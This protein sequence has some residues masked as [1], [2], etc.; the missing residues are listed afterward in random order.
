MI[1]STNTT[2]HLI[3]HRRR[4]ATSHA[5]LAPPSRND[6]PPPGIS[7]SIPLSSQARTT[8]VL[9][10]GINPPHAVEWH[11][12]RHLCSST[13]RRISFGEGSLTESAATFDAHSPTT[14]PK[15]TFSPTFIHIL[16]VVPH[17]NQTFSHHKAERS[18]SDF[19]PFN[20][21]NASDNRR[22]SKI[23]RAIIA[24][25]ELTPTYHWNTESIPFTAQKRIAP[26]LCADQRPGHGICALN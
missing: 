6:L 26:H 14:K 1:P 19:L 10:R 17:L 23:F 7:A 4:E 20:P 3:H 22:S 9:G 12:V 8:Q 11:E 25:G 5:T 15:S 24:R 13:V 2:M 21:R 18:G 16:K